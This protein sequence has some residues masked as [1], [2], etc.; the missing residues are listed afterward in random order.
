M[1]RDAT[2][3]VRKRDADADLVEA[4]RRDDPDA[5]E[6]LVER[7]GDRVYRLALHLTGV[8]ADAEEAAQD[9]LW[10]IIRKIDMFRGGCAL[11]WWIYRITANASAKVGQCCRR[12]TSTAAASPA[13][14]EAWTRGRYS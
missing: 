8:K 12:S 4:L 2:N 1:V 9:A 13:R 14:S 7:Y 5:A 3:D 11:G 10:T 6:Q